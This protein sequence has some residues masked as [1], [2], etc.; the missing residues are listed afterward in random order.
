MRYLLH[1]EIASALARGKSVEQ[2]LGPGREANT[3]HWL[4]VRPT[5]D[6]IELWSF[7]VEDVGNSEYIDLYSFPESD[8]PNDA[9][10]GRAETPSAAIELAQ[11][12]FAASPNCWL[13]Q[14]VIQDLYAA[15]K[16]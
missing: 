16:A 2:F 3:I 15:S 14:G 9:P 5:D 1:D 4:E 10:A 12:L 8:P 7:E 13:N 6:Q 11:S